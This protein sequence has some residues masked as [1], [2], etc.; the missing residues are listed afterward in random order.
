MSIQVPEGAELVWT[1]VTT[2]AVSEYLHDRYGAVPEVILGQMAAQAQSVIDNGYDDGEDGNKFVK[3]S[4][5][6]KVYWSIVDCYGHLGLDGTTYDNN[7][8]TYVQTLLFP[9]DY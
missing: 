8:W 2:R 1:T 4:V 9:E 5:D 7:K 6:D 3:V